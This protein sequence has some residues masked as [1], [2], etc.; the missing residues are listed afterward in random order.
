MKNL[1]KVL[2]ILAGCAML[3]VADCFDALSIKSC[4]ECPKASECQTKWALDEA[5]RIQE[6]NSGQN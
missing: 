1:N 3:Q 5:A 4:G 6:K 2:N